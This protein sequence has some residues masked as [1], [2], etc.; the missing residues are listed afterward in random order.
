MRASI[1]SSAAQNI[2][3]NLR[4]T[5]GTIRRVRKASPLY[6]LSSWLSQS[7]A[8]PRPGEVKRDALRTLENKAGRFTYSPAIGR[9]PL[10]RPGNLFRRSVGAL[11][12]P[13][14]LRSLTEPRECPPNQKERRAEN[15]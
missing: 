7:A 1:T 2:S 13:R 11:R 4:L 14:V 8:T 10:S 5:S 3:Q 9:V 6:L 15:Y 12:D